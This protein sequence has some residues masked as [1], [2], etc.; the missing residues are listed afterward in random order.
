MAV[1]LQFAPGGLPPFLPIITN[2]IGHERLLDLLHRRLA[3]VTI[4]HHLNQL[5]VLRCRHLSQRFQV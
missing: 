2:D 3:T 1:L 4:Q 5:Q